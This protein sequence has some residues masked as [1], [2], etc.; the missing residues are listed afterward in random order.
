VPLFEKGAGLRRAPFPEAVRNRRN[1][2]QGLFTQPLGG[3]LTV[4][5]AAELIISQQTWLIQTFAAAG[6]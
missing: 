3:S 6:S 4:A 1:Q 5:Q 2:P